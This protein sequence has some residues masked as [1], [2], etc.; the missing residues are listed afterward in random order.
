MPGCPQCRNRRLR[1]DKTEPECLKCIKKGLRCSGQGFEC[2]FSSHMSKL[3][4]NPA[5]PD[6]A[7]AAPIRKSTATPT[8]TRRRRERSTAARRQIQVPSVAF[9]GSSTSSGP[10][11]SSTPASPS[12]V[13]EDQAQDVEILPLVSTSSPLPHFYGTSIAGD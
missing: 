7:S 12:N 13:F 4:R 10:A 3:P 1:C 2:R 5:I 8:P 6:V 9:D 11:I